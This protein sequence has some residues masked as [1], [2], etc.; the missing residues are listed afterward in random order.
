MK[1][2]FIFLSIIFTSI[3]SFAEIEYGFSCMYLNE[4]IK[5][6]SNDEVVC[7]LYDSGWAGFMKSGRGAGISCLKKDI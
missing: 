2:L 1:S 7:Y 3:S 6:C 4:N 5:R